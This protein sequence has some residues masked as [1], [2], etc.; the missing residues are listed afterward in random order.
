MAAAHACELNPEAARAS[1]RLDQCVF[2]KNPVLNPI[3][4]LRKTLISTLGVGAACVDM[5][6]ARSL[7]LD[8]LMDVP[9]PGKVTLLDR[10][11]RL[12]R[13]GDWQDLRCRRFDVLSRCHGEQATRARLNKID[14]LLQ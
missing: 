3:K 7:A 8:A 9:I 2:R 13:T 6:H 1:N 5:E 12:R 11:D 10:I 4:S 14:D